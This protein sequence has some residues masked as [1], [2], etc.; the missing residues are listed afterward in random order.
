MTQKKDLDSE[1][2]RLLAEDSR[3]SYRDLAKRLN[4]SHVNVSSRVKALEESGVIRASC[5]G[6]V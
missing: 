6:H 5:V 2:L 1:I 3:Q 4:I